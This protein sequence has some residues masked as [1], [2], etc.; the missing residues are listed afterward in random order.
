MPTRQTGRFHRQHQPHDTRLQRRADVDAVRADQIA[1]QGGQVCAADAGAGQFAEAGVDAVV[2]GINPVGAGPGPASRCA[3]AGPGRRC[4]LAPC[5]ANGARALPRADAAADG[6]QVLRGPVIPSL[7]DTHSHAFQ[8]A[9]VGLAERREG[10][11]DCW[12]WRGVRGDLPQHRGQF[13][14]RPDRSARLTD[15]RRVDH[16]QHARQTQIGAEFEAVMK[17]L[18]PTV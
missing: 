18:W 5:P 12:F 15:G 3:P 17:G 7:V 13:G 9:F 6:A 10:A 4:V 8:R 14:R 1:L 2:G 11:D 16:G